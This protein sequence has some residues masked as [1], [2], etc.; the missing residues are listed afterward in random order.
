MKGKA[1]VGI[2]IAVLAFIMAS[3]R[4]TLAEPVRIG[5]YQGPEAAL[6]HLAD[7]EGFFRKRGADVVV[8]L[9]ETGVGS[10]EDLIADKL[11][12]AT[13]TEFAFVMRAF[14]HKDLRIPATISASTAAELIIR[15]DRGIA[16]PQDFKG[17]RIAVVRATSAEFFFYTYLIFNAVPVG[18]VHTVYMA[19]A[20]MVKSL[21]GG[22]IDAAVC[23]APY[24]DRM[25]KELGAN[26]IR[27]SAQSG[28]EM[29]LALFAK[30]KFLKAH[31]KP[32][33]QVAAALS[34]AEDFLSK[35]PDSA[36]EII[37]KRLRLDE[38]IFRSIWSRTR[39]RLEL[40]QDLLVL[41]ER[42]AKWAIRN[43]VTEN[44]EAPNYL[45]FF[46]FDALDKVKPE[47]VSIVH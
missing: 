20:E 45:N 5:F 14:K 37:G 29:Y 22:S 41:M 12:I 19:P 34:D 42:E 40:T 1:L 26:S 30:E 7:S 2:V 43:K 46:S 21:T 11:D 38:G 39:V 18:S 9:Y 8:R 33:E 16:G 24:T 23:W 31:P 17:K 47:A 15:K 25:E 13:A 36:K 28:Q 32:M 4:P 35:H 44:R 3:S 10:V 27:W 6:V